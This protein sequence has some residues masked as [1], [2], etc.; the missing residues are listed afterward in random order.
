MSSPRKI[1][2]VISWKTIGVYNNFGSIKKV[3]R[4]YMDK[5]FI[6]L[7]LSDNL[8]DSVNYILDKE[9]VFIKD[10]KDVITG[11]I[12][13]YDIALQF[14][15]LSE[16]FIE[17]ELIENSIRKL[18]D[19]HIQKEVFV[20]FCKEQYPERKIE[21]TSDLTFGEYIG[22]IGNKELWT[23]I[24]INLDRKA[25]TEKLECIRLIRNDIMHFRMKELSHESLKNLKDVSK[26]FRMLEKVK[27][28]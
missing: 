16:P 15:H 11:V 19:N 17:I 5:N 1:E 22:I 3:A 8:L 20:A 4:D 25:F 26:F 27:T 12:T 23:L 14:K 10:D 18:I 13:I 24:N 6:V 7:K 28:E 2:G 21:S 9:Y